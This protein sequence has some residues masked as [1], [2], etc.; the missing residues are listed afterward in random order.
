MS[1]NADLEFN[2][3]LGLLG[4]NFLPDKLNLELNIPVFYVYVLWC[5]VSRVIEEN[6]NSQHIQYILGHKPPKDQNEL[7]GLNLI[8][9]EAL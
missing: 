5:L 6:L 1:N 7:G 3:I 2:V 4:Q 9:N 8:L